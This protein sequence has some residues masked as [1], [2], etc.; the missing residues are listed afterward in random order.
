MSENNKHPNN[1]NIV[2][3]KLTPYYADVFHRM[4]RAAK[5]NTSEMLKLIVCPVLDHYVDLLAEADAKAAADVLHKC[6]YVLGK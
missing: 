2:N 1:Q 6:G 4:R 3:V 5:L